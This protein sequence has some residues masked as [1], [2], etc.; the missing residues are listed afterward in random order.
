MNA[1]LYT[2]KKNIIGKTNKETK[3]QIKQD[4]IIYRFKMAAKLPIFTSRHFDFGENLKK[5]NAFS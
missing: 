2:Q 5:K 3:K 4:K 1:T